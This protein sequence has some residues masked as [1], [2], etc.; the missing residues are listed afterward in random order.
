VTDRMSAASIV[1]ALGYGDSP[2]VFDMIQSMSERPSDLSAI[3]YLDEVV[4][5][6]EM[7]SMIA[8]AASFLEEQ[9]VQRGDHV[10]TMFPGRPAALISQLA[11]VLI[12]GVLVP[13]PVELEGEVLVGMLTRLDVSTVIYDVDVEPVVSE[14]SRLVPGLRLITSGDGGPYDAAIRSESSIAPFLERTRPD[15]GAT[16]AILGTSGTTG[17]PKGV[18]LPHR[19]LALIGPLT[20]GKHGIVDV[21]RSYFCISWGHGTN[22]VQIGLTFWLGGTAVITP[23]FSVSKFWDDLHARNCTNVTLLA[24]MFRMLSNQPVKD[25]DKTRSRVDVVSIGVPSD[26]WR[27]FE[28]RFNVA[29]HEQYSTTDAGSHLHWLTNPGDLPPGSMKPWDEVE[30][31]LVN[32]NGEDVETDEPG[33]LLIRTKGKIPVVEYYQDPEAS[34]EKV[35]DGWV[36]MGDWFRKDAEG[37]Y[38]FL[39]RKRDMIRRRAMNIAPADIERVLNQR[40]EIAESVAIA[41]PSDL[42]EDEVKVVVIPATHELTAQDVMAFAAADLPKFMRPRYIELSDSLPLTDSNRVQKFRLE[43]NWRTASTWDVEE[44]A[45]LTN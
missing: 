36:W 18:V 30:V 31:R 15:P 29:L 7:L 32:D 9:G 17:T 2:T 23:K 16:A 24:A 38:W 6:R 34:K 14:A 33:E 11:A 10:A 43:E 8:S 25:T 35:A 44:N 22:L 12:G 13:V 1:S 27:P 37:C 39:G 3:E 19:W 45:F 5:Y 21:P 28:E 40:P 41:V 20:A 42:G 4:S 26:L